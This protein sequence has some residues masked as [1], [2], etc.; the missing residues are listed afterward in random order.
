MNTADFKKIKVSYSEQGKGRV[1]VLLHGFLGSSK[2]WEETAKVLSKKFRVIAIDLLGHGETPC[3]GYYHPMELL[4]QSVKSVLDSIG[5]RRYVMVGHSMGGYAALAFAELF[6]DNIS[7]LC[8][9][10]S[11]SYADSEDKKKDRE[12]VIR[13]VKKEHKHYVAEVVSSLF[14][15]DNLSRLSKEVNKAKH[16]AEHVNRQSI[17]NSLEGM[18]ER[19]SRD[20][21]LKFAEYPI[22]FVVGKKDSAINYETMYPQFA[23]CKFPEVLMLDDCGHMAMYEA[24]KESTKTIMR[25]ANRCFRFKGEL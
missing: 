16:I 2:I 13:L 20:L 1:I 22:L 15:P 3:I 18:K 25:F 5:V 7:G 10:N 6:P 11:T 21:I 4:A 14:A 24:N 19:K 23:L 8:L 17:I 12:R 9:F